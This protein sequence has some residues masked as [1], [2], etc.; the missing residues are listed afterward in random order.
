[1]KVAIIDYGMGNVLSVARA[2]AQCGLNAELTDHYLA[3]QNADFVIL[4]GVGAIGA[5][6]DELRARHLIDAIHAYIRTERPL[7]GICLGMQ[8]LAD[9]S[10]EFGEHPCLGLIPGRVQ[11]ITPTASAFKVPSIGWYGLDEPAP[12]RWQ[13]SPFNALPPGAETY[14]VHSYQFAP[15][16]PTTLLASYRLG[17]QQ[18]VA[19]VEKNQI[20]GTQF[21]PEKS[22]PV[23]LAI[24]QSF[25]TR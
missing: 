2:V 17:D 8:A 25:F 9:S 7:L 10:E 5:A 11:K 22:G 1:M 16:E 15:R 13:H 12:G 24:L 3:I 14:F 6:M 19:A 20:L 18:I 4:P 21:H 23:G